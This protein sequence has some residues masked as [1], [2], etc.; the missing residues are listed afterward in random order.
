MKEK[1][2]LDNYDVLNDY[3]FYKYFCE[4]GNETMRKTFLESIGVPIKGDLETIDQTL[5]PQIIENKKCILDYLGETD[6]SFINIEMQQKRTGDFFERIFFY[7][8]T[9]VKL[10]KG[11][12]YTKLKKAIFVSIVNFKVNDFPEYMYRYMLINIQRLNDIFVDKVKIIVIDLKKFQKMEKD[13]NKKKHQY[14]TFFDKRIGHEERKELGKMDEGLKTAAKKIE[15]ALQDDTAVMLYRRQQYDQMV[16]ENEKVMMEE[17]IKEERENAIREERE[18]ASKERKNAIR[19]EREKTIIEERK[20][21]LKERE[22][23]II[24]LA[25]DLKKTGLSIEEIAK[26]TGLTIDFIEKL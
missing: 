18:K 1:V 9:V 21:A 3:L 6:D 11:K 4:E 24:K 23:E 26:V 25:T 13:L 12:K 22:K 17:R 16:K 5:Y 8:C 2:T 15:E 19:E 20:K 10:K 14:L 7:M